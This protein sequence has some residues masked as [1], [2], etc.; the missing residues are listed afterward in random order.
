VWEGPRHAGD[1]SVGQALGARAGGALNIGLG[2]GCAGQLASAQE[3]ALRSAPQMSGARYSHDSGNRPTPGASGGPEVGAARLPAASISK[4]GLRCID[5]RP[6][7][8]SNSVRILNRRASDG[9]VDRP[10]D[11]CTPSSANLASRAHPPPPPPP[12]PPSPGRGDVLAGCATRSPP[13][14]SAPGPCEIVALFSSGRPR[15][16]LAI[17]G[18]WRSGIRRGG[19]E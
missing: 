11:R 2:S 19:V 4:T 6:R 13:R 18:N 1:M 17:F 9:D 5:R 15:P 3:T 16:L 7:S 10:A 14:S 8:T 12:P